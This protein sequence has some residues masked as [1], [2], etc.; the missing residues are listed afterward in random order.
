MH[1][2]KNLEKKKKGTYQGKGHMLAQ[3]TQVVDSHPK[4]PGIPSEV[5]EGAN[6]LMA[7]HFEYPS[8]TMHIHVLSHIEEAVTKKREPSLH[9]EGGG[10]CFEAHEPQVTHEMPHGAHGP[11]V[12]HEMPH[13][14]HDPTLPQ[15]VTSRSLGEDEWSEGGEASDECVSQASEGDMEGSDTPPDSFA[16]GWGEMR[17]FGG[18]WEGVPLQPGDGAQPSVLKQKV[19]P[20]SEEVK[21]ARYRNILSNK[22]CTP[23]DRRKA[24]HQRRRR[25]WKDA[26]RK[27]AYAVV[28]PLKRDIIEW[29]GQT[30]EVDVFAQKEN[31]QFPEYW[32]PQDDAFSK[33][34]GDGRF[35][36]MNP[37]FS[38]LHQVVQKIIMDQARGI[39]VVPVWKQQQWFWALGEV[40]VDWWDIPQDTPIFKDNTGTVF[41]QRP[42]WTTRVILFDAYQGGLQGEEGEQPTHLPKKDFSVKEHRLRAMGGQHPLYSQVEKREVRGVVQGDAEDP[43]C[44]AYRQKL[45]HEFMDVFVLP[46]NVSETEGARGDGGIAH[47]HLKEG[48]TPLKCPPMRVNGLRE[49][50]FKKLI[51]K[52]FDRG[53]LQRSSSPWAARA[54]IVPKPGGKWRLVIDYRYLNTHILDDGQPL[55]LT[56]DLLANQGKNSVW[57]IFDLE[58]GFHQMH[59]GESSRPLT[60]FT[61][62]WGLFEWTVLP[63][64]LKTAPSLYQRLVSSCLGKFTDQYG[65]TPYIDDVLHGTPD[66]HTEYDPREPDKE[67]SSE[68]LEKHY[69]ELREFF[70]LMRKYKLTIKPSKYQLFVRK[71]KFLGHILAR[72]RR[73]A[74]PEKT[75]MVKR[76]A[77]EDIKTPTHLKSFLGFTQFYAGYIKGYAHLTTPLTDA[78]RGLELTKQQKKVKRPKLTAK[79][80]K[81][82]S[83]EARAKY[84]NHIF[85]TPHMKARFEELKEE[86]VRGVPLQLPNFKDTFYLECDSSDYAV[87]GTLSQA[88]AQGNIRPVAFFSR[89]LQGTSEGGKKTGQRAWHIRCQET[90]AIIAS[91]IKFQ[92][93]LLDARLEIICKTDHKSLEGWMEEKLDTM[94][95]SIARRGRWHQFLSRYNIHVGYVKGEFNQVADI[96]SRWAFPAYL[97]A[98]EVSIHGTQEAEDAWESTD[99][100]EREWAARELEG[101]LGLYEVQAR[102]ARAHYKTPPSTSTPPSRGFRHP[103]GVKRGIRK[104][105]ANSHAQEWSSE[106]MHL[107]RVAMP[108]HPKLIHI[109]AQKSNP[110][111]V[112]P[113]TQVLFQDWEGVYE[114]DE[115]LQ[116]IWAATLASQQHADLRVPG[117][118]AHGGRLRHKGRIAVPKALH[119]QVIIA[120]HSYNHGGVDKTS[121]LCLRTFDFHGLSQT[122]LTKLIKEVITPCE[123]CATTKPRV[124]ART[125]AL[126]HYP[127]PEYPF[128]SLAIDFVDLPTVKVRGQVYDIILVIVCRLTGYILPIPCLKKGLDSEKV[129]ELFLGR[130]VFFMGLPKEI[131]SDNA[132]IINSAFLNA[133]CKMSGIEKH[134]SVIYNHKTNGRAE[135]AVKA[136]VHSLRKFLAQR[137]GNWYD[138]LPLATWAMNDLPGVI[139][140]YSPHRLVFGRDPIGW[141]ECPP[142]AL[143]EGCE[144]AVDFFNR[145]AHERAQVKQK[146]KAIHEKLS[147]TYNPPHKGAH[148]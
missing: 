118:V 145:V 7:E 124:G 31:A 79:E 115:G 87:G 62:P 52:F 61:T 75:A 16:G 53:M 73:F 42:G 78:L 97:A 39:I 41:P 114:A 132:P 23:Q 88:D 102:V 116:G 147:S 107:M 27:E 128:S 56:E 123:V 89:K 48:A 71:V 135:S 104:M 77:P 29:A 138:S 65:T 64:G 125:D 144:S 106:A 111:K 136:V 85:W 92:S 43:R 120:I 10:I 82:L 110:T 137:G 81:S 38:K 21:Q 129:A 142:I 15:P 55:P 59:L 91:L 6:A 8:D 5:L 47:I 99:V 28:E 90:Y 74:D 17:A 70:L 112:P 131:L 130:C 108:D 63:M 113:T 109:R 134:N 50:E 22:A 117:Y 86:F 32:T 35:L 45:E 3:V 146:L 76:W 94:S 9:G 84:N 103:R 40:A 140:P 51:D 141:G 133:L 127:I 1:M 14:T 44:S 54:F 139:A 68:C 37:P 72:G 24:I 11:H 34:W 49:V 30:P 83:A 100:E 20:P 33:D 57:S 143:G 69:H 67:V 12:T 105:V 19:T 101:N 58:D 148:V 80:A 25:A 18:K 60:A 121:E 95:G 46:K 66:P 26:F 13:G 126:E 98:P 93:W 4:G 2:K 36:W 96:C 119:K 122:N